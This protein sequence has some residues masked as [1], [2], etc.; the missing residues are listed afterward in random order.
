MK[1]CYKSFDGKEFN[2]EKEC[3]EYEKNLDF[4]MYAPKGQTNDADVC[5]VVD[6]KTPE[7]AEN[8]IKTCV[9][10]KTPRRGVRRNHAGVYAWSLSYK[11]YFLLEPL[12]FEALK[13][14]IKDTETQE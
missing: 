14:Y 13:Q 11:K 5:Y 7:A 9:K 12:T 2:T 3:L 8:F 6:I 4:K 1:I 10:M